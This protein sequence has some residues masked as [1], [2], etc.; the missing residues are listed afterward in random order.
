M[1]NLMY[2]L[3]MLVV[4]WRAHAIIKLLI[5]L[6]ENRYGTASFFSSVAMNAGCQVTYNLA[7]NRLHITLHG[8]GYIGRKCDIC[9]GM[10]MAKLNITQAAHAVGKHRSTLQRHIRMARLARKKMVR[11][12]PSY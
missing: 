11:G 7:V 9:D 1:K 5:A 3:L 2:L 8:V 4:A 12:K 10:S 6:N